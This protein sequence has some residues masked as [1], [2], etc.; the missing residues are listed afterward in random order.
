MRL[1]WETIDTCFLDMDGTLLDLYYDHKVWHVELPR[2]LASKDNLN[3]TEAKLR[4]EL[5]TEKNKG[6][7]SWYDLD[8]WKR[9]LDIDIDEIEIALSEYIG[10]RTGA[11]EFLLALKQ[12]PLTMFLVTN[13]HPRGLSRKLEK[14][15]I[16]KYFD[17]IISSHEIGLAKESLGF[18]KEFHRRYTFN[19]SRSLLLDDNL[20][21]LKTAKEFGIKHTYGVKRPNSEGEAYSSEDFFLIENYSILL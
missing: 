4:I 8:F 18:W 11:I 14:T 12:K 19:K 3:K 13:A 5:I 17:H 21:V 1:D 16:G 7:L 10:L 20:N 15:L 9:T 6:T 2:R